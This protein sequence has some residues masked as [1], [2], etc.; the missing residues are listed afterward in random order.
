MPETK[1]DRL[2]TLEDRKRRIEAQLVQ[3]RARQRHRDKK[4]TDRLK[5]L[6]GA[7]LLGALEHNSKLRSYVRRHLLAFHT[8]ERDQT[9]LAG[10]LASL[11]DDNQNDTE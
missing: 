5:I 8:R 3:H 2:Q 11:P 7:F 1:P 10:Y 6:L 9:F 4:S